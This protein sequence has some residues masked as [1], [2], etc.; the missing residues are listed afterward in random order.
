MVYEDAQS[1]TY[2]P[3]KGCTGKL[4]QSIFIMF[5]VVALCGGLHAVLSHVSWQRAKMVTGSAF[6]SGFTI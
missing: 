3:V 2:A 6:T 5:L 4:K 1:V